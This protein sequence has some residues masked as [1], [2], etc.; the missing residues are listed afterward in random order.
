MLCVST[1]L[2]EAVR[3]IYERTVTRVR[4]GTA[5]TNHFIANQAVRQAKI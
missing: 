4:S 3:S 5:S 1:N 2:V